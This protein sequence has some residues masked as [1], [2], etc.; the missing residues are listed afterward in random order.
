MPHAPQEVSPLC[1]RLLIRFIDVATHHEREILWPGGVSHLFRMLVVELEEVG[2]NLQR[3]EEGSIG[4]AALRRP[5][6]RLRAAGAGH[7]DRRMGFLNRHHP[8]V[9]DAEMEMFPLPPEWTW[10]RP[11]FNEEVVAFL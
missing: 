10:R 7:P 5:L 11:G 3:G 1:L 6:D 4:V 2:G 8:G 9:D